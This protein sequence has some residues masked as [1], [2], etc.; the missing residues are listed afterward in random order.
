M[1]P[2]PQLNGDDQGFFTPDFIAD[3]A[4]DDAAQRTG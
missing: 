1:S 3:M 2:G 4:K